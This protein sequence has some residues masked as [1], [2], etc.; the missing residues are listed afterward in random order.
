[1][2]R[3]AAL[4]AGALALPLTLA[5]ALAHA[6]PAAA[7]DDAPRP[8]W[9]V[10]CSNQQAPTLL[11]CEMS[12]SI[13]LTEGNQRLASVILRKTAGEPQVTGLYTLPVGLYL[14]AGLTLAVDE[15]PLATLAFESCDAQGCYASGELDDDALTA[16]SEG[17]QLTLSIERPTRETL[18]LGFDLTGFSDIAA[19]MP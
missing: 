19:V 15:T 3:F 4:L 6:T 16:L 13:V 10:A 14:P 5:L 8:P 17:T 11:I 12:Q 7:Q 18:S 2:N 1:M 9:L